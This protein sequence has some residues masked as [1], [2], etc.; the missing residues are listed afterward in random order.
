MEGMPQAQDFGGMQAYSSAP[1]FEQSL[2]ALAQNRPEQYK[3]IEGMFNPTGGTSYGGGYG[4]GYGSGSGYGTGIGGGVSA[5]DVAGT[6]LAAYGAYKGLPVVASK[7]GGL[8]GLGSGAAGAA[9]GNTALAAGSQALNAGLAGVNAIGG[10]APAATLLNPS[11]TFSGLPTFSTLPT[12]TVAPTTGLAGKG[13]AATV[14]GLA[15]IYAPVLAGFGGSIVL[16]NVIADALGFGKAEKEKRAAVHKAL[17]DSGFFATQDAIKSVT[18]KEQNKYIQEAQEV[19]QQ[20]PYKMSTADLQYTDDGRLEEEAISKYYSQDP[21]G[22]AEM[23]DFYS[24]NPEFYAPD[25]TRRFTDNAYGDMQRA[26]AAY[27]ATSPY[28]QGGIGISPMLKVAEMAKDGTLE[29]AMGNRE[30]FYDIISADI[31]TPGVSKSLTNDELE[32]QYYNTGLL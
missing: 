23:S 19:L 28:A 30:S 13:F 17:K 14:K 21:R 20:S 15:G 2:E 6:A 5:S 7:V 29:S 25:G 4:G 10:A 26:S 12:S 18:G 31:G 9:A 32:Q 16:G 22:K 27:Q 1:L 11:V 3:A 24:A 8:L